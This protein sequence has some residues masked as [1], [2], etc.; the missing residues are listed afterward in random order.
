MLGG[1]RG[2]AAEVG[3]SLTSHQI[4]SPITYANQGLSLT[5]QI[6]HRINSAKESVCYHIHSAIFFSAAESICL[7]NCQM[8]FLEI[9]SANAGSLDN[10]GD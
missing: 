7:G 4:P 8:F 10:I 5:F 9:G 2:I 6:Q 1:G 3:A